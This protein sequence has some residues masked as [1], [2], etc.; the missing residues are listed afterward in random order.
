[1]K[2]IQYTKPANHQ[3]V[4]VFIE[5]TV[6]TASVPKFPGRGGRYRTGGL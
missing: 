4:A 5:Q 6:A 3:S 2:R 1:M